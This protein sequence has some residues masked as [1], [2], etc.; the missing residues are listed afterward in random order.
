MI[1]LSTE[2]RSCIEE[3]EAALKQNRQDPTGGTFI[4]SCKNTGQWS[5]A[6]CHNSSG[7][8]WCVDYRGVIYTEHG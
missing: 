4:P 1:Y 7:Y 3:R 6:Q 8:C 2:S 5:Q